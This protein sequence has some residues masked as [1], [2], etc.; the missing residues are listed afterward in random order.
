[1]DLKLLTALAVAITMVSAMTF[2]GIY[3]NASKEEEAPVATVQT[4]NMP[5]SS[6]FVQKPSPNTTTGSANISTSVEIG[7]DD[8]ATSVTI[9]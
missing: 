1:M 6:S 9:K 8:V 5:S 4:L 3:S 7:G 2:V